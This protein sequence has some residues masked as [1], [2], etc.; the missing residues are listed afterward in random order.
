MGIVRYNVD[1][2]G[3]IYQVIYT[4]AEW[5]YYQ[6]RSK[7]GEMFMTN[8]LVQFSVKDFADWKKVFDGGAGLRSSNGELSHQ[9]YHDMSDPNKVTAF[10]QWNSVANA[11]KF[12]QSTELRAATD[13][14][15]VMGPPNI[16]FLNEA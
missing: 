8:V 9:I 12:F 6:G 13:K 4:F 7:T 3:Y 2:N 11:Q 16:S 5:F 14:A 15:G 1:N 10:Y